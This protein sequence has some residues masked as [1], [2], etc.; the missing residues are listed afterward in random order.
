MKTGYNV[1]GTVTLRIEN[2]VGQLDLSGDYALQQTPGPFLYLNTTNTPN[3]G[4][5]LRIANLRNV[6]GS[7]RYT[8][9]VPAGVTYTWA[10]IWCD[11]FNVAMAEARLVAP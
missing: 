6:S 8:F 11:P 10:I 4:M 9:S 5:P 1:T 2:G 3:S 7:Q